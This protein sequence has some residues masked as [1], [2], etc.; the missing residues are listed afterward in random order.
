MLPLPRFR[1][2]VCVVSSR[3]VRHN[4]SEADYPTKRV[5]ST[6]GRDGKLFAFTRGREIAMWC[7]CAMSGIEDHGARTISCKR[8]A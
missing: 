3:V 5:I 8:M 2:G 1:N 7:C 6:I 4:D